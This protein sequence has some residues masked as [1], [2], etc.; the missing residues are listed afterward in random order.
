M[1][2]VYKLQNDTVSPKEKEKLDVILSNW[3]TTYDHIRALPDTAKSMDQLVKL[4]VVEMSRGKA[5]RTQIFVRLYSRYKSI[6]L[7]VEHDQVMKYAG[8]KL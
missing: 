3:L 1:D 5:A 6:R 8:I 4:M 7:K 2:L